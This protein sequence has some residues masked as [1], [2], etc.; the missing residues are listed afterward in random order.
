MRSLVKT[1]ESTIEPVSLGEIKAH[2]RI[3]STSTAEDPMLTIYL[4]GARTL[5]ENITGRALTE[6][7]WRLA[8]DEFS[9][10][11]VLTPSPVASAAVTITYYDSANTIQTL[12]A[13]AYVV[14]A[15][16]EPPKIYEA[17]DNEW[18]DIYDREGAVLISFA[19]GH[20]ASLIP[21]PTPI[22][23]W[24]MLRAGQ[25]FE[26]REPL[27]DGRTP[28]ELPRD[29]VDGLLDPYVLPEVK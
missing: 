7:S 18:P 1:S 29:F 2:L 8:L 19:A 24:I 13:T 23:Q 27:I 14:D 20:A 4:K 11:I 12:A 25:M 26:F 15:E 16:S 9:D 17:P 21:V 22:K 5:A 6:S 10:T 3:A 28:G